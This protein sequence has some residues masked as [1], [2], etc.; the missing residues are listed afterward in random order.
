MHTHTM[1][2]LL[3]LSSPASTPAAPRGSAGARRQR[4]LWCSDSANTWRQDVHRHR[5]VAPEN[6]ARWWDGK[7]HT[8]ETRVAQCSEIKNAMRRHGIHHRANANIR[9]QISELEWSF[10]DKGIR[11]QRGCGRS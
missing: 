3:K 1:N 4:V 9:T 8:G 11:T 6:Y 7:S 10:D 5:A 2:C